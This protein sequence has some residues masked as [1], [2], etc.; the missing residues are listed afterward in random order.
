MKRIRTS[1][2]FAV[3][4]CSGF[5]QGEDKKPVP[6]LFDGRSIVLARGGQ[7]AATIV[8]G[9][10]TKEQASELQAE[11]R[12]LTKLDFPTVPDEEVVEK[13]RFDYRE[14]SQSRTLILV[15]NVSNNRAFLA[16]YAR[17]LVGVNG[18]YPGPGRYV[19]RTLLEPLSSGADI[20]VVG[21]SDSPGLQ[22]GVK[23]A[24]ALV[25]SSMDEKAA[26]ALRPIVEIGNA[27]GP[28]ADNSRYRGRGLDAFYW[29]ADLKAG[30][31]VKQAFLKQLTQDP[32]DLKRWGGSHYTWEARYRELLKMLSAGFFEEE[33]VADIQNRLYENLV[34][35]DDAWGKRAL[36]V[37]PKEWNQRMTRHTLTGFTGQLLLADY[38]HHVGKLNAAQKQIVAKHYANLSGILEE[39]ARSGRYRS[40]IEGREGIDVQGNLANV[41]FYLGD[42]SV[43]RS[44]TYRKMAAYRLATRDNL[45]CHAG[46][47]SYIGSRPGHQFNPAPATGPA[48]YL[49]AWLLRDPELLGIIEMEKGKQPVSYLGVSFP[50]EFASPDLQVKPASPESYTGL[51]VLPLDGFF[52]EFTAGFPPE[53]ESFVQHDAARGRA[54]DRAVFREGLGRQDSYLLLQG[55]NV[56]SPM[57]REGIFGNAI[58]RYTELGSLFLF[59][60]TQ[61]VGSWSRS[62]MRI[63]R[64]RHDPQSTACLDR[65]SFKGTQV[66]AIQSL[67]EQNGG[68]AWARTLV[69]RHGGYFIVIDKVTAHHADDYNISCQWRSYHHGELLDARRFVA[70]DMMNGAQMHIVSSRP[71][72]TELVQEERDGAADPLMVRQCQNRPMGKSE[73]VTFGNLIYATG[74][75]APRDLEV[76]EIA[77]G[78]LIVRGTIGGLP[79]LALVSTEGIDDLARIVTDARVAYLSENTFCAIAAKQVNCPGLEAG[80]ETR[81]SLEAEAEGGTL[82]IGN[83]TDTNISVLLKIGRSETNLTVPPGRLTRE[84]QGTIFRKKRVARALAA[85]W[86]EAKPKSSTSPT[87]TTRPSPSEAKAVWEQKVFQLPPRPYHGF[88]LEVESEPPVDAKVLVDRDHHRW[89]DRLNF[90]GKGDWRMKIQ[91]SGP[92]EVESVHL[93]GYRASQ[94]FPE[95]LTFDLLIEGEGEPR[96]VPNIAPIGKFWYSECEKYL[97]TAPH[98]TLAIP[99]NARASAI[100]VTAR[101]NE[102]N[103]ARYAFQEVRVFINDAKWRARSSLHRIREDGRDALVAVGPDSIACLD[104]S[105]KEVWRWEAE[106]PILHHLVEFSETEKRWLIGIWPASQ[107]FTLLDTRGKAVLAPAAFETKENSRLLGGYSRPHA[108]TIWEREAG[109]P[110]DIAFFP[111]YS[112]GQIRRDADGVRVEIGE[113]RGGKA[114]LR[115]PDITGDGREELFVVGRYEN[116]NGLLPS[117]REGAEEP[118]PLAGQHWTGN[119]VS[120][121]TGWS[122]G[123]MELTMYHGAS[124]VHQGADGNREWL[125]VVAVNPG[126]LNFYRQP[127]FEQVWDHFNHPGNFCH[128]AGD[129]D[130]DGVDEILVGRE[131]GFLSVY[132]A[133][134]GELIRKCNL[135]GEVR[136]V[137]VIGKHLVV[138]TSRALLF[139][140]QQY[141][142]VACVP[143]PVESVRQIGQPDGGRLVVA[144]FSDGFLRAFP[145]P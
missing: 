108:V 115:V 72:G 78:E 84:V 104:S 96:A 145:I 126:G 30:A 144:A 44:G 19:V 142:R 50:P 40:G 124:L 70:T 102:V 42:E 92:M 62:V 63:S 5:L 125:G 105:G 36:S 106:S 89:S 14:P 49:G 118:S 53:S 141:Q 3:W 117:Q 21:G 43:L 64:G 4:L 46:V 22:A 39:I 91:L 23:R 107:R 143:G 29:E 76:R 7:A 69:R 18:A 16:L 33:Q 98:P 25:A 54:F 110:A 73:S 134:T 61:I 130:G 138:G 99:V 8:Y 88:K 101:K 79:E 55:I 112:F 121:W 85:L 74:P 139:L 41:L 75:R 94:L 114:V 37:L 137:L 15:G 52:R 6:G 111:H 129:I 31:G 20:L 1:F 119:R 103:K 12:K 131:D 10:P 116:N 140:D 66:S 97:E 83:P 59:S 67:Q 90:P 135:G 81:F 9:E 17:F 77:P 127:A 93:V 48:T 27:D 11:L 24:A 113:G 132:R 123:N 35:T 34:H 82:T 51:Q 71:Y 65:G 100:T 26:C 109:K 58:I 47:D 28:V 95:G 38:L 2:L 68:A 13:A 80:S 120:N 86:E 87:R 45:G 32:K 60:N 57:Y 136:T 122:A 133:G 56:S 128:T